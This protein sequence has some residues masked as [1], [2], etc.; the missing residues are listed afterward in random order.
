VKIVYTAGCY[1]GE[2]NEVYEN[3][4]SARY[5]ARELW[6]LGYA[7]ICPHLN[8]AFMD[9]P[10]LTNDHFIKG[11]L[12]ILQFCDYIYMLPG[13]EKSEG[14]KIELKFARDNGIPELELDL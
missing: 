5:Y 1:R 4:Q 6:K 7:V 12:S 10:D 3:I 11:D 14:A 8:T 13:W 9:A 2:P